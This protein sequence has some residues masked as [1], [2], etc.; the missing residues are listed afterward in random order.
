MEEIAAI[1]MS[2]AVT[3]TGF[4]APAQMPTIEMVPH[5]FMVEH[6]CGGRECH[7]QG[8]FTGGKVIYLDQNLDPV[9]GL[10]DSSVLL[11]EMVHY[12]QQESPGATIHTNCAANVDAERQAYGAQREY[13]LRYGVYRPVGSSMHNVSC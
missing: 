8:W 4:P 12:L 5:A 11:H 3:L 6:A 7:V 2:W 9:K 10:Y 13:L 1:M